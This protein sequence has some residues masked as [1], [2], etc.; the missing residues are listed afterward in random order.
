[1]QQF[2]PVHGRE[3]VWQKLDACSKSETSR[4]QEIITLMKKK[5]FIDEDALSTWDAMTKNEEDQ[6]R[7]G[8]MLASDNFLSDDQDDI[9][10]TISWSADI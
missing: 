2:Q 3:A 1:M 9:T 10:V 4:Q 7:G 5:E 8:Q 6:I